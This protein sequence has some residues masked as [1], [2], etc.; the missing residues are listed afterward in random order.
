MSQPSGSRF[1]PLAPADEQLPEPEEQHGNETPVP[2]RMASPTPTLAP[3]VLP[4]EWKYTTAEGQEV[5]YDTLA[6]L[7]DKIHAEHG[8]Q[9]SA[10]IAIAKI[11]ESMATH[12]AAA[13]FNTLG[14]KIYEHA[15]AQHGMNV[16]I[17]KTIKHLRKKTNEF[18]AN[19]NQFSGEAT[20]EIQA[21]KNIV[22]RLTNEIAQLNNDM[23]QL[24]ANMRT[25]QQ[26]FRALKDSQG[27]TGTSHMLAGSTARIK[28]AEPPKYKGNKGSD[29]TLEQ[30]LQKIGLWLRHCNVTDDNDK[31]LMALMY[32]EGGAQSYM[33]DYI[34]KAANELPLGSWQNFVDRL[35]SGYRQLA[36]ERAAQQSLEDLCRKSHS[37]MASFAEDFRRFAS[38]SGYADVE[39]IY[40]IEEQVKKVNMEIDRTMTAY[41]EI[42]PA[43]VPTKWENFLDWVLGVEMRHRNNLNTR[44][45]QT[46]STTT[47]SKDPN[48]MDIDAV[49]KPEKM[50]KEQESWLA[51]GKCF[52][53]GKHPY[54]K[55]DRCRNPKY[56]GFYELP[57]RKT[58]T[59]T[60]ARNLDTDPTANQ[61]D[62]MEYLRHA[63]EEFDKSKGK[64]KE[65]ATEQETIGQIRNQDFVL[66][67][68]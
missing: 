8:G 21:L 16:V 39:L 58:P 20:Q 68:L 18:E 60:Q 17:D 29:I 27:I 22:T 31:I 33:D 65:T 47:R 55:G 49:R 54:K 26:E 61:D 9:R 12:T 35:K 53:C 6:E 11:A 28:V 50:A 23:N 41:C 7:I 42:T 13:V 4:L 32:L 15:N 48:A 46:G 14:N 34:D 59:K 52:R 5:V 24:D 56:T 36:P 40:R 57:D 67:M 63:L 25:L 30:W 19:F 43:T 10:Y 44:S 37:S 51:D 66:E 2:S 45:R 38:K 3:L 1:A 64:A 62:K